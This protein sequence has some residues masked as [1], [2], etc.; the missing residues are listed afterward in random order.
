[1]D[2]DTDF[3]ATPDDRSIIVVSDL[4]L[5]LA[6]QEDVSR[7]LAGLLGYLREL[8]PKGAPGEHPAVMA[9]GTRR[10]LC[11]PDKLVL[12]GDIV[13]LWSP[14]EDTYSSALADSFPLLLLLLGCP[15]KIVYV[16]GNHDEEIAEIRGMFPA[17]F[18]PQVKILKDHYPEVPGDDATREFRGLSIGG[19]R[20]FFL[21]GQ[22]FDL[23]FKT[24]GILQDYPGWV[25]K[26]YMLFRDN[27][28]LVRIVQAVFCLSVAY[29]AIP[30][31]VPVS[32]PF[33]AVADFLIGATAVILLFTLEPDSIRAFWDFANM[34]I[35][36]RTDTIATI[37]E[38]ENYRP[39]DWKNLEADTIVFGH[40]HVAD[41]SRD[42]YREPLQRRF[43]NTG[44]WGKTK[45]TTP[46]AD[47][48]K[49]NSFVYIDAEG[50]LLLS[51]PPGGTAP[52]CIGITP[53]GDLPQKLCMVQP[54]P[55][56]RPGFRKWI[57]RIFW[58]GG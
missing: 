18:P 22:Q 33:A 10:E 35:K 48:S 55:A 4:H 53:T 5:G 43:I 16:A 1:M 57:K 39:G 52:V 36:T 49:P 30:F 12:L 29:V 47:G 21:H 15:A 20:Y 7:D 23:L 42:R 56:A 11:A 28:G 19:H 14:R 8:P 13:D 9:G 6:G 32:F 41:D 24:A 50:P 3:D 26:N 17:G 2:A 58:T 54:A 38:E 25:A 46:D 44:A 37:V 51:W 31:I 34:R 40:T 45:V 27:P